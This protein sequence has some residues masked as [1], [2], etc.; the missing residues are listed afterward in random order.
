MTLVS[1]TVASMEI[2]FAVALTTDISIVAPK[3]EIPAFA[4]DYPTLP[5]KCMSYINYLMR[6]EKHQVKVKALLDYD[7]EVNTMIL[8]Y[9]TRLGLKVWST[10][11]KA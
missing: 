1:M 8:I 6:F 9:T 10:N 4:T 3:L 7:N 11:M 5:L 2:V